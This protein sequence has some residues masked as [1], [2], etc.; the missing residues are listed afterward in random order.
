VK[1]GRKMD[2]ETVMRNALVDNFC[3]RRRGNVLYHIP[4][5]RT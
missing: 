1:K 2:L 4:K 5:I 3:P